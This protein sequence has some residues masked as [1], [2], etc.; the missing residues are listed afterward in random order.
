MDNV[1]IKTEVLEFEAPIL[2]L[3]NKII[4]LEKFSAL[5]EVDLSDEIKKLHERANRL[6]TEIY[7]NLSPW[8]RV[9]LARHPGRPDFHD[10]VQ[11]LFTDFIELHGDRSF[12]DDPALVC[13][14]ARLDDQKVMLVGM[15]RG[16][17]VRERI[18]S[19]FGCP[20]PEGYRKAMLK[21]QLAEKL[22]IPIITFINTPGAYPGIGAEERGQALVIAKNIFEMSKLRTPIIC[23]VTGEG[24]S[25]GA[26]AIG[27]GDKFAIMEN[28][29]FSV[30]SPEGCAAILWKSSTKAPEAAKVLKLIPKALLEL[31]IVDEIVPEPIGGAH[32]DHQ[33]TAFNIKSV[34]LRY[35][36]ELKSL[37]MDQ[38]LQKRYEK[39]RKIGRFIDDELKTATKPLSPNTTR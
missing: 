29:Y 27:V 15:K 19:N 8:Q 25:G 3:E 39:Y 17:T 12:R 16:K 28:A 20:H 26:L 6:K 5:A 23:L 37:P 7:K 21:M 36:T 34:F 10:F 30:I 22:R 4:E 1:R 24:G 18:A 38:L 33:T 11:L 31:G 32:R 13:G 9:Q 2:E 14:L 35:L